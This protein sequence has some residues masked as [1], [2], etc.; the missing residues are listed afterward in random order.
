LKGCTT[1]DTPTLT[2]AGEGRRTYAVAFDVTASL[3]IAMAEGLS[4]LKVALPL[5][6]DTR[7]WDERKT[8]RKARATSSLPLSAA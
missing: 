6:Y 3:R 7:R 8:L 4:L 5:L 1:G 2:E